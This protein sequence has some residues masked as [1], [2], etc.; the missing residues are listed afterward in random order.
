MTAIEPKSEQ[1]AEDK[2]K[3]RWSDLIFG[4]RRSIRYHNF[5]RKFFDSLSVWADFLIIISAG[6]AGAFAIGEPT[7]STL[8]IIL[9]GAIA[10]IGTLD[11]VIGFK[12]KARDYHDL[13]KDFSALERE[14]TAASDNKTKENLAKFKNKRLEIQEEE[15]PILRVLNNYCHNEL[16]RATDK[17][18]KYYVRIFFF[19]SWLKQWF[20]VFPSTMKSYGSIEEAKA[21][22]QAARAALRNSPTASPAET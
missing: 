5:R 3:E 11:L 2:T 16:C 19:Q 22:K 21:K 20:D 17:D 13:V 6:T 9:S 8:T 1:S 14:M 4:V 15:P 18:H 10:I 12:T 7:K